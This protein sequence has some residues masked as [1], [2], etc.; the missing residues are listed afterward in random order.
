MCGYFLDGAQLMNRNTNQPLKLSVVVEE[1]RRS[2]K[3]GSFEEKMT[4]AILLS[5]FFQHLVYII[6]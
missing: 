4:K 6:I 5:I 1:D 2:N 3:R